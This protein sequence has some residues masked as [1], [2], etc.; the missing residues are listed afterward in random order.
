MRAERLLT[1]PQRLETKIRILAAQIDKA[2]L[3]LMPGGIDYSMDKVQGGGVDKYP[4]VLDQILEKEE[5][6]RELNARRLWL[7]NV[8]I[9]DLIARI[10]NETARNIVEAFYTTDAT[11]EEAGAMCDYAVASAY[12]Y[13]EIGLA[14]I[15]AILDAER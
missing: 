8:R 13:R 11:M 3:S 10:Q 14:E 4:A 7:V 2:R 15:Q 5:R 6:I 1:E 9:P 12:R